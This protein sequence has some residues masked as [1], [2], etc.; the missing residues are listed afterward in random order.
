MKKTSGAFPLKVATIFQLKPDFDF[1]DL[2][3]LKPFIECGPTQ[4]ESS[5]WVSPVSPDTENQDGSAWPLMHSQD[6]QV[7]MALKTETKSVPASTVKKA[8]KKRAAE[9][10]QIQGAKPG[11][12][13]MKELKEEIILGL[14]PMAPSREKLT[15]VWFDM[16]NRRLV[17]GAGQSGAETVIEAI[18]A[19][20]NMIPV[21]LYKT[22]QTPSAWMTGLLASQQAP[23]GMTIDSDCELLSPDREKSTIRY[24]NHDL[25]GEDIREHLSNGKTVSML[26]L[27]LEDKVSF[28][29]DHAMGFRKIKVLQDVD[30]ADSGGEDVTAR[31]GANVAIVTGGCAELFNRILA[32]LGPAAD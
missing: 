20:W 31:F 32:E 9:L 29:L 4:T 26:A 30:G 1:K 3:G 19:S 2:P 21:D 18:K 16:I 10:E 8:L 23:D 12:M 7:I 24:T 11:R 15:Y 5:G 13:Q 27:T 28:V 14:L 6:N 22:G 25:G 17:V